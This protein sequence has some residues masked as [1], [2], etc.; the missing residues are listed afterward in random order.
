V[1]RQYEALFKDKP[2]LDVLRILGLF[3]RPADQGA[4]KILR[5]LS[6]SAW[7]DALENLKDARLIEY[8]DPDGPLDCHPLI[9]EHFAEEYRKSKPQEFVVAQSQLYEYYSK[10]APELPETLEEMTPLFYAVYHGCQAGKHGEVRRGVYYDRIRRGNDLY[11]TR[12][13]RLVAPRQF[14]RYAMERAGALAVGL[15]SGVGRG[16]SRLRATRPRTP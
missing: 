9:R 6:P 8:D 12:R 10:L 2:E 15:R 3:D 11:L 1:L 4:L 5:K 16:R 13:R 7:A 14:F